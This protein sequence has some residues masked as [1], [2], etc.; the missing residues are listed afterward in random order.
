[1][2]VKVRNTGIIA[3]LSVSIWTLTLALSCCTYDDDGGG[4]EDGG[5][6]HQL[7]DSKQFWYGIPPPNSNINIPLNCSWY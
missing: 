1:M 6:A 7:L 3:F 4:Y 5:E 2:K